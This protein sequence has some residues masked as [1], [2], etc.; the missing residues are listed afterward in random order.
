[1]GRGG[2]YDDMMR[3]GRHAQQQCYELNAVLCMLLISI[4]MYPV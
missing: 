3:V 2:D 1:M 4:R